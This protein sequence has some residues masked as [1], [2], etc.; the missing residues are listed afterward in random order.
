MQSVTIALAVM[1][2]AFCPTDTVRGM[3]YSACTYP[4]G[5]VY[6]VSDDRG[7]K[8]DIDLPRWI[9]SQVD[10]SLGDDERLGA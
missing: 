3:E 5:N 4:T 9:K 1:A 10:V 8:Y 6:Y 7:H 2:T